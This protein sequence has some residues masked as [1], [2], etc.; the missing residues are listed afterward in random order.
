MVSLFRLFFLCCFLRVLLAQ[1]P[2]SCECENK[3]LLCE[4]CL[5][6]YYQRYDLVVSECKCLS[7]FQKFHGGKDVCCSNNCA[8]C[9]LRGCATCKEHASIWWNNSF[10]YY[11]CV[12]NDDYY[13]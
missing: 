4:M 3:T 7:N 12:C 10:K 6:L 2:V 13:E 8:K 1:C 9:Y 5:S 11:G